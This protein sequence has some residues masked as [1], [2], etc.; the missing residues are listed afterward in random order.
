MILSVPPAAA[1]RGCGTYAC[2]QSSTLRLNEDG[3]GAK[4]P[5]LELASESTGLSIVEDEPGAVEL[6][7]Q[8]EHLGLARPEVGSDDTVTEWSPGSRISIQA[9]RTD[10]RCVTSLQRRQQE[11][12][13]GAHDAEH[14]PDQRHSCQRRDLPGSPPTRQGGTESA[15]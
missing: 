12:R 9:G 7:P 13:R 1:T 6:E 10:W 14:R 11:E 5:Q 8:A 3:S 15:T 4:H 2:K